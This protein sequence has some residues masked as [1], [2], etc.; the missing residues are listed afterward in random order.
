MV[1][2]DDGVCV[3]SLPGKT[4]FKADPAAYHYVRVPPPVD[5]CWAS[6]FR[7][8]GEGGT[9]APMPVFLVFAPHV[10]YGE[11]HAETSR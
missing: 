3:V 9:I 5:V 8:G 2:E 1:A 11:G 4:K 10:G 6:A 7:V